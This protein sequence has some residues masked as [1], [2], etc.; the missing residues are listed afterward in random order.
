MDLA[1]ATLGDHLP[2]PTTGRKVSMSARFREFVELGVATERVGLD[3]YHVGE[4]HFCDYVLSSPTPILAAVAERTTRIRLSTAVAL[5]PNHDPVRIA[6]DYAT[7]DQLSAGRV[8][9]VA[10]RG[11]A[12]ELYLQYG[13]DPA[14]SSE[15]LSEAVEL[16]RRLWTEESVTWSG[17]IRPPLDAVR[18]EPRPAQT[19]HPPIWISTSSEASV[20]R[21]VDLGVGMMIATVSTGSELPASLIAR[22]RRRW[23]D[24]G[25]DPQEA[26]VAL[27]VHGYVGAGTTA[28]AVERFAPHQV[29]YLTW[30]FNLLRAGKSLPP[31]HRDFAVPG[32][33]AVCGSVSDVTAELTRRIE[34]AGGVDLL[35]IQCDQGGMPHAEAVDCLERFATEVAPRLPGR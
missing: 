29:A 8:E 16:L 20:D 15:L 25:R 28:E 27:H 30:V 17:T 26:R 32:A 24:A 18:L 22:Y 6:E 34:A 12:S 5:L 3:G 31:S 21:A 2:D 11:V 9:V 1:A 10:G 13:Q 14:R 4:H 35:V 7:V 23:A 19:P 33:Q